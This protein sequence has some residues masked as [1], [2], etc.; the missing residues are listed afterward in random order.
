MRI[1]TNKKLIDIFT[2]I[3]TSFEDNVNWHDLI[4][5]CITEESYNE[6]ILN[7]PIIKEYLNERNIK[8]QK[9]IQSNDYIDM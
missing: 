1:K 8:K 3:D 6:L 2:Y 4:E 7:Y 5:W 9:D